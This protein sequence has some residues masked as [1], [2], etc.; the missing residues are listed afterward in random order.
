MRRAH[1]PFQTNTTYV[2]DHSVSVRSDNKM[3]CSPCLTWIKA[4]ITSN[5][6][7]PVHKW[8]SSS[9]RMEIIWAHSDRLTVFFIFSFFFHRYWSKT[10]LENKKLFLK[11]HFWPKTK[12]VFFHGRHHF[13]DI[14]RSKT[15]ISYVVKF[16]LEI[17]LFFL[18][19]FYICFS[20]RNF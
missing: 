10:I 17:F 9:I 13:R 16:G 7:H 4:V 1:F 20:H 18:F 15:I 8:A 19:F 12:R 5:K 11:N 14:K 3:L 6:W 2:T